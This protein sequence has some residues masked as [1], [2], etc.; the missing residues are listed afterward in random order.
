MADNILSYFTKG[1]T[2]PKERRKYRF[3][4]NRYC[5]IIYYYELPLWKI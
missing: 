2:D 3:Y 5:I 1:I 4:K